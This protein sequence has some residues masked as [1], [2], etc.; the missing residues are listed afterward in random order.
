MAEEQPHLRRLQLTV[1][2]RQQEKLKTTADEL[3]IS[4][5]ELVRR[6]LDD[7]LKEKEPSA[8]PPGIVVQPHPFT[9]PQPVPTYVPYVPYAPSTTGDPYPWPGSTT[10]CSTTEGMSAAEM[11]NRP[12][13]EVIQSRQRGP[14]RPR[15]VR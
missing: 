10:T 11:L 2:K 3:Q 6:I 4:T 9:Y 14:G 1:T 5:S 7:W 13:A 8:A 12:L 15:K